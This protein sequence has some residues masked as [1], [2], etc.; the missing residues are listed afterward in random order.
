MYTARGKYRGYT[1]L[2]Y[3]AHCGQLVGLWLLELC[4]EETAVGYFG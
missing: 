4:G 1:R 3:Q 2:T